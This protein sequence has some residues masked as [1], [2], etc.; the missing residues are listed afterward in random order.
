MK[1]LFVDKTVRG[2]GGYRWEVPVFAVC[3]RPL[4]SMLR[5]RGLERPTQHSSHFARGCRNPDT[6]NLDKHIIQSTGAGESCKETAILP[7][8]KVQVELKEFEASEGSR[9]KKGR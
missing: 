2:V 3:R 8:E 9:G 4:S 7:K 5:R 6:V 1:P